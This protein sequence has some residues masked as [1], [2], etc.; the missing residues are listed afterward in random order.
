MILRSFFGTTLRPCVRVF[1]AY[2]KIFPLSYH[3]TNAKARCCLRA[4]STSK[5]LCQRYNLRFGL[6][7]VLIQVNDQFSVPWVEANLSS[8]KRFFESVISAH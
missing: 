3:S 4:Y 8:A 1:W 2:A 6:I 5:E 7:I